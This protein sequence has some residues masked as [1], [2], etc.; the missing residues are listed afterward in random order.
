[1]IRGTTATFKFKMPHQ[2]QYIDQ[3][4]VTFWQ[5]GYYGIP[6]SELPKS[7]NYTPRATCETLPEDDPYRT[8]TDLIV[9]LGGSQTKA[10]TDKLKAR[11]QMKASNVEYTD[12]NGI[13]VAASTF[14]SRPELFTVYPMDNGIID[15]IYGEDMPE[16]SNGY[17]ILSGG[18]IVT[19]TEEGGI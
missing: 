3:A 14:G 18:N 17:V 2:L 15:G 1:M 10:F 6:G 12:E 19:V 5:D 8:S 7:I 13:K 11:V 9:I 4:S 16:A